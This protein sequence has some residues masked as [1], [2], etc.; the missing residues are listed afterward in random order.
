M[1]IDNMSCFLCLLFISSL[2][3]F[4]LVLVLITEFINKVIIILPFSKLYD[5]C[6][7]LTISSVI[8]FL[9]LIQ[10]VCI[11]GKVFVYLYKRFLSVVLT[12]L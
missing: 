4:H 7:Y 12:R 6:Q 11:L 10:A 3:T 9:I 1:F 5:F 2:I 8:N